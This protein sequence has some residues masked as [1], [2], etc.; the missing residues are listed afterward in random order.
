MDAFENA[1]RDRLIEAVE[2]RGVFVAEQA[3]D[4]AL[5]ET[6]RALA[7]AQESEFK[8]AGIGVQ[9]GHQLNSEIRRDQTKWW[10]LGELSDA[11]ARVFARFERIKQI[12]NREFFLGLDSFEGHYAIYEPGA[13]YK[14]HLDRFK[15]EDARTLSIVLFLNPQWRSEQGGALRV[16]DRQGVVQEILPEAGTLVVFLSDQIPH[17]V[18]VTHRK[19]FS[20]A[21]WWK[22]R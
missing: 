18:C 14:T 5:I 12:C 7:E 22:R 10:E 9:S 1:L 17:E 2:S 4:S 15:K 20:V 21:G 8:R 11:E 13:F 6:L 19:R 3:I 16:T